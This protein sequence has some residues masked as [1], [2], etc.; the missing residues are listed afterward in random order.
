MLRLWVSFGERE[1]GNSGTDQVS[2]GG[3]QQQLIRSSV[4]SYVATVVL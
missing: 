4:T 1:E 3:E 2:A